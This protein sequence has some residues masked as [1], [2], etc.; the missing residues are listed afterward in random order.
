[1]H[2]LFTVAT[3]IIPATAFAVQ[4]APS[5]GSRVEDPDTTL[6]FMG[7][8]MLG[9]LVSRQISEKPPEYFWGDTLPLLKEADLRLLNLE[10]TITTADT[11]WTEWRKAFYY[12]AVPRA[13]KVLQ[14]AGIDYVNLANNHMLDFSLEGL[15]DTLEHLDQAGIKHSGAGLSLS[16]ASQPVTLSTNGL[17][18]GVF[19]FADHF[20]EWDVRKQEGGIYY[21]PVPP[22]EEHWVELERIIQRLKAECGLVVLSVHW[23]PNMAER[24]STHTQQLARQLIDAGVDI[25]HGH[26]AHVFQ[27]AEVYKG[28]PIFY[29][30][31][32]FIDDYAVKPDLRNDL[33]FLYLVHL[34][35]KD[36]RQLELVPVRISAMQVNRATGPDRD[37]IL[38]L[39]AS[40]M[41][42]LDT[43]YTV[44]DGNR[45]L[46]STHQ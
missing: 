12:K 33:S 23:G 31:G 5:E 21:V 42:P 41:R 18:I 39:F 43:Q 30:T 28:K 46:I 22:T 24:P 40:R 10:T 13:A 25:I 7:D 26:S 27:G 4:G 14:A 44:T 11:K 6:A 8:T 15:Q 20:K 16:E 29:D 19:S 35:G 1:M 32:E 17:K 2:T 3:A 45:I 9:R 38:E 36:I 37:Q 34:E